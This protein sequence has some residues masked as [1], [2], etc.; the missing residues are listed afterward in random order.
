M[1]G[2]PSYI[3]LGVPDPYRARTFYGELFGWPH[4]EGA[5]PGQVETAGLS[6]GVHGGDSNAHFEVFFAVPDLDDAMAKITE[7]GGSLIGEVNDSPGFG[8]W[9]ECEDDQNVAFGLRETS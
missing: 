5:G 8:R 4:E 9:I 6:I 7:L 3:E 2:E 1:A